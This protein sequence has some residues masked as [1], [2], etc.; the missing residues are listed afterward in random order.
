MA[1]VFQSW[2]VSES[3]LLDSLLKYYRLQKAYASWRFSNGPSAFVFQMDFS[4]LALANRG[5][6]GQASSINTDYPNGAKPRTLAVIANEFIKNYK[7]D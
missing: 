7:I 3:G 6:S 2:Q 4:N 5:F 1:F